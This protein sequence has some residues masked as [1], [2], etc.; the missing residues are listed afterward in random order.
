MGRVADEAALWFARSRALFGTVDQV[1]DQ[2][3]DLELAG[4]DTVIVAHPGAFT[5]PSELTDALTD[6]LPRLRQAV[7]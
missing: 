7:G 5:L 1:G 6:V 2:F 4:V 3:R